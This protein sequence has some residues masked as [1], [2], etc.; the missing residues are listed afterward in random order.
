MTLGRRRGDRTMIEMYVT[1]S[2]PNL[3]GREGP[4]H[5]A[6]R[7]SPFLE[8]QAGFRL[9]SRASRLRERAAAVGVLNV[10]RANLECPPPAVP[11]RMR[12]LTRPTG[13]RK[14]HHHAEG[15]EAHAGADRPAPTQCRSRPG[16]RPY[17]RPDLPGDRGQRADLL[18]LEEPLRRHEDPGAPPAEG[19]RAGEPAP[20]E[21]GGRSLPGRGHAEGAGRGKLLSPA[22]KR[23]AVNHLQATF[24]ISERRRPVSSP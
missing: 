17:G 18:P 3:K 11:R 10:S 24:P 7:P 4:G 9:E 12:V 8:P 15:E 20:E 2:A 14:D 16:R 6:E 13:P 5:S 19:A 21:A 1:W 22:R 23:R